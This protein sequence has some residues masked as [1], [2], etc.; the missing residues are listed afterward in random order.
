MVRTIA[1]KKFEHEQLLKSEKSKV[2]AKIKEY[3][4]QKSGGYFS[5]IKGMLGFGKKT[6]EEEEEERR[7]KEAMKEQLEKEALDKIA[8]NNQ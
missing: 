1:T 4:T 5:G 7:E 3:E 6:A 8:E 2:D